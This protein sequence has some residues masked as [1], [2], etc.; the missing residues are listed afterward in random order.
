[1][2]AS[3]TKSIDS[4]MNYDTDF[5][6]DER[7]MDKLE[8]ILEICSAIYKIKKERRYDT[9]LSDQE[10]EGDVPSSKRTYNIYGGVND[11]GY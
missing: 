2:V 8:G 3:L 11:Y 10:N 7:V 6:L 4:V 9:E 1:M 5:E